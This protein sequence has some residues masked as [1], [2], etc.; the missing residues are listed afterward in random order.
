VKACVDGLGP[1]RID[2][3]R[4]RGLLGDLVEDAPVSGQALPAV[5]DQAELVTPETAAEMERLVAAR[6]AAVDDFTTVEEWHRRAEAL[7]TYLAGTE[8][9]GPMLGIARRSEAR[10]GQMLGPAPGRGRAE[11]NSHANSFDQA[12]LRAEFRALGSAVDEGLLDYE[13][14]GAESP[15]R[16]S[17]AALTVAA[18]LRDLSGVKGSVT[19]EWYTPSRY[20]EA[21]RLVLGGIDLDPASSAEANKTVKAASFFSEED[22]GLTREW[23][24]RVWLNPPYG[25]GTGL[26]ISKLVEEYEL[27]RVTA[28]VLLINA[29]GFDSAWFQPLWDHLLCFTDHRIVFTSP[30]RGT[31]G[32]ANAN[33]FAYLGNAEQRFLDVF[34]EFGHI[35]RV[36]A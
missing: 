17:R 2:L 20:I 19:V 10:I 32:P 6:I 36:V 28:A 33:L 16:A 27:G 30:Q 18:K 22:N 1:D 34:S 35:V 23:Q 8:S 24:G 4:D 7:A 5:P 11:M 14:D 12:R 31:G 13:L 29:Y 21:A 26:F 25:K 15:W 3:G 9:Q